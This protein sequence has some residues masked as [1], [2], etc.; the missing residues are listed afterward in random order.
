MQTLFSTFK[1]YDKK[2]RRLSIFCEK[3]EISSP[4]ENN[5]WVITVIPCRKQDEF[6]KKT[7]KSL[8]EEIKTYYTWYSITGNAVKNEKLNHEN[9]VVTF[10]T[11]P[12]KLFLEWCYKNYGIVRYQYE[13]IHYSFIG[14]ND[15]A[16][17]TNIN[18]PLKTFL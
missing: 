8:Y 13:Q 7:G 6:N 12:K 10:E 9:F 11:T 18:K 14:N 2:G 1:F 5:I 3:P 17:R 16:I 15:W 4:H